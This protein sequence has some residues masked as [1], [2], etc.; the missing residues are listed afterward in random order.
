MFTE[1]RTP[2]VKNQNK[3]LSLVNR[4]TVKNL[5][6]PGF[7]HQTTQFI[8]RSAMTSKPSTFR[9]IPGYD[10]NGNIFSTL[11]EGYDRELLNKDPASCLSGTFCSVSA[12]QPFGNQW[13]DTVL[14]AYPPGSSDD[15]ER[16]NL[17]KM[18]VLE[19]FSRVVNFCTDTQKKGRRPMQAHPDWF[20]WTSLK[21][22]LGKVKWRFMFQAII[23][24]D[25]GRYFTSKNEETQQDEY[26]NMVGLVSI[27]Q[28]AS[29]NEFMS[30]IATPAMMS[31][32]VDVFTNS[33]LGPV[34]ELNGIW[35]YA[36]PEEAYGNENIKWKLVPKP[37]PQG[38][39]VDTPPTPYPL[40]EDWVRT[41]WQP[42]TN[43]LKWYTKEEQFYLIAET[44]GPDTVNYFFEA[45]GD[46]FYTSF[47]PM[48]IRQK[49]YGRYANMMQPTGGVSV[50]G[51]TS[52]PQVA[53][54]IPNAPIM[55]DGLPKVAMTH[56]APKAP[57]LPPPPS[58]PECP[59]PTQAPVPQEVMPASVI[60]ATP[61]APKAT[62]PGIPAPTAGL[63]GLSEYSEPDS[64][65]HMPK[66][67]VGLP[68]QVEEMMRQAMVAGVKV[69]NP[70]PVI[71][72]LGLPKVPTIN[73]DDI[74]PSEED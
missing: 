34:A 58:V 55:P 18:S 74:V 32:P 45:L 23:F 35:C 14:T 63:P 33:N 69:S 54:T 27:D 13:R 25:S 28:Q 66:A 30:G 19:K 15:E 46:D 67:P 24:Q 64:I 8:E 61:V 31:R 48:D 20:R 59:E 7:E 4:D 38:S 6:I 10:S 3:T 2:H 37:Y 42:W 72:N 65:G 16:I 56:Q 26:R 57:V 47:I 40:S 21:G 60:A 41:A 11:R 49:G 50:S 73:L 70:P 62:T 12:I 29:I 22:S 43:L 9:I 53:P 5:K 68:P 51:Y 39:P 52:I 1:Q 36:H 17:G 44:F 71:Q